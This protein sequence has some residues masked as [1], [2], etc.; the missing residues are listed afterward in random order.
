MSFRPRRALTK[1]DQPILFSNST[2]YAIHSPRSFATA[3]A[4][5]RRRL[6]VGTYEA[7]GVGMGWRDGAMGGEGDSEFLTGDFNF[8][9]ELNK[10]N[11]PPVPQEEGQCCVH[12]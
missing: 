4:P 9:V 11:L 3:G 5:I 1:D 12:H 6:E 10:S 2:S 8:T 7:D